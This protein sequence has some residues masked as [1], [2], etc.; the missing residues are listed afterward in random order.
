MTSNFMSINL[1]TQIKW[2]SS[3]KDR[4]LTQEDTNNLTSPSSIKEIESVVKNL[5]RS[6]T[7]WPHW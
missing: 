7:G 6:R 3:L 1:L 2:T 4:K 5:P